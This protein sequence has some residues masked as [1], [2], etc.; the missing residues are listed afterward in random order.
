M[1]SACS[2][3][4]MP[5]RAYTSGR[6]HSRLSNTKNTTW[7]TAARPATSWAAMSMRLLSRRPSQR[8]L[9]P[10]HVDVAPELGA[11]LAED[12][13][14]GEAEPQVQRPRGQVGHRHAGVRAV[15]VLAGEHVEQPLVQ[16]R[17]DAPPTGVLRH[18][19]RRL[20][21]RPVARL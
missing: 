15:Q 2:P 7:S 8:A 20:D 12:A 1:V 19:H 9:E 6:V 5:N 21:R 10:L 14:G 18:V 3:E 11:D 17:P 13:D 16:R 4:R